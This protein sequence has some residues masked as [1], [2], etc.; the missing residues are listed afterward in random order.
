MFRPTARW[1]VAGVLCSL[2]LASPAG[3]ADWPTWR[4]DPNRT[5][6]T[7]TA[8][9]EDLHLQW[10][11]RLGALGPAWPDEPRM[12]FDAAY[13]PIVAGQTMFVGSSRDD[14]VA[15]YDVRD[16]GERW[17]FYA[18]GPVRFAPAAWK[19]RLF[20]ASD[21][22]QLYC[23]DAAGGKLLWKFR[24]GPS[25]RML[26]G[27]ERLISTWP[28][29]G[30]PVVR[31]GTVYFAAGI[32]P[33]MGVFVYALDAETGRVLWCND[34]SGAAYVLQPHNSAAFA[35]LAPQGYLVAA[36]DVLLVPNG[37]AAAA[38]LD[39]RTGKLL[40]FHHAAM[41]QYGHSEAAA[42]GESFLNS[43]YLCDLA[44]GKPLAPAGTGG[45][46]VE[47][48]RV[49][50]TWVF[51][52][53]MIDEPIAPAGAVGVLSGG[54]LYEPAGTV[55]AARDARRPAEVH[56]WDTKGRKK[57]G[58]G[59]GLLWRLNTR[60]RP[61]LVAGGRLYAAGGGEVLAVELPPADSLP[62]LPPEEDEQL[63]YSGYALAPAPKI[64]WRTKAP[65]TPETMIAGAER[66]FLATRE[67]EI[68]C[69]GAERPAA[70]A[71]R[72]PAR[73]ESPAGDPARQ[74]AAELLKAGGITEGWCLVLGLVDGSLAEQLALQSSL[75]VVAIDADAA[76]VDAFRRR[77]DR[78]RLPARRLAA[79]VADPE[80]AELAPYLASLIVSEDPAALGTGGKLPLERLL[81]MLRP[82]GGTLCLSLPAGA[83]EA[84]GRQVEQAHLAG[85]TLQRAGGRSLLIRTG[86]LPGAGSW[87][88]QYGNPANTCVSSDD[89]VRAPLGLLWFGGPSNQGILPRHGHGPPEQ[90]L[91]GRLFIE[92]PD[93]LRA[94]DVYTGRLLWQRGL[95]GVGKRY[96]NTSHEPGAGALGTNFVATPEAVY[97]VHG[98]SC[99]R[100][101]SATGRTVGRLLLPGG[102]GDPNHAPDWGY[103][104]VW[105]DLL[106]AGSS[107]MRF[108]TALFGAEE[109]GRIDKKTKKPLIDPEKLQAL[110]DAV[111]GWE[112][113]EPARL[114]KVTY[115]PRPVTEID[116]DPTPHSPG[117]LEF[118]LANLNKLLREG[119]VL[120][121][122][123]AGVV[124]EARQRDAKALQAWR[125]ARRR[126]DLADVPDPNDVD[127]LA[128]LARELEASGR[129]ELPDGRT[130][131]MLRRQLLEHCYRTLPRVTRPEVGSFTLDHTASR[132][133]VVMDRRTGEVRWRRPAEASYRHN[134]IC[135]GGGKLFCIDRL[136]TPVTDR[137]LRRG[138]K[139]DVAETLLVLD[140]R[141]GR[142]LWRT[143][144][145]V[146]G[147]WLS[148]SA[149]HDVLIQAGR[150]SRD[151]LD[152]E[153]GRRILAYRGATGEVLWDRADR[154]PDKL[155]FTG[156]LM[157]H[158]RTIITQEA[159]LDLLTGKT[160]KHPHPLTGEAIDWKYKRNYGCNHVIASRHL[161]TFRSAAAGFYDLTRDGGT[162]NFGGFKSSCTS[163]LIAADGVLNAPDYTR[164]CTCSYQNQSSLAMVHMP[165]VETWTFQGFD[166]GK[167]AIRRLGVNFGAPG[168]RVAPD[169][170]LWLEYPYV[171]GP[172]PKVEIELD[173]GGDVDLGAVA[174]RKL[175]FARHSSRVR[176]DGLKW[177]AASGIEAA[178]DI[179]IKLAGSRSAPQT[180]TVALHFA[181]PGPAGKGRRT[182]DVALQGETVLRGLDIAAETGGA[183]TPLV[184]TFRKVAVKDKLRIALR[185][186]PASEF[187]P[188]LCGVQIVQED[189]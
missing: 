40:Y 156:P 4:C 77:I 47:L 1:I 81:A 144:R 24:A 23:L 112:N 180:Y 29:R 11:L 122:I 187:P 99:L 188:V 155:S 176:G 109:F 16:G 145:A 78:A 59:L 86:P 135:L 153:P 34:S 163:N 137:M 75:R 68:H 128:G 181:E 152:D 73:V 141:T 185:Q 46:H 157:L 151:M 95:P 50:S 138:V 184:K 136:P 62:E 17:R 121:R 164:T 170:T 182:F 84:L 79:V 168:D 150:P 43:G 147:T 70:P 124:D 118:L 158:G 8:L 178:A 6:S 162:G 111:R 51:H 179:A 91:G 139:P 85:A 174:V 189:P 60:A 186:G 125:D 166:R 96:D 175:C 9:P 87:T 148:Y 108:W 10:T 74:R 71:F 93:L 98:K 169:G 5:A 48:R 140:L 143:R 105:E 167:E 120:S 18:D 90:V 12:R 149:E 33:F 106:V 130:V 127:T 116:Q 21:D 177:V 115:T 165:D 36:G 133:L 101:D 67:G 159:A 69:Y 45:D 171:G 119:D 103:L 61:M 39:R 154:K 129:D 22:G 26:L 14:S 72:E 132:E 49:D 28:A 80:T 31:D 134:A 102:D 76:K 30:A 57:K 92:G 107:P 3:A 117:D 25:G 183:L 2:A 35:G 13:Q 82:Y 66:L 88:H 63:T 172:T 15:A 37:R 27:N 56:Y 54:V 160:R 83:H 123:P 64:A 100:L 110:A 97:V 44:T 19:D 38:G 146:F 89:L 161:L 114:P 20:V 113:F 94:L 142:E 53:A 42:V 41:K 32:W 131:L 173:A 104:G 55:L 126:D 65:G 58:L 52:D 7:P